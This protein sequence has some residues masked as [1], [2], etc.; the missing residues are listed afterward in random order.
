MTQPAQTQISLGIFFKRLEAQRAAERDH[1]A[2]Y[3]QV[4]KPLA[5]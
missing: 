3:P 4:A 1:F 2:F 5:V